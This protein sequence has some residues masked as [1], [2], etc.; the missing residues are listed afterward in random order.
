MKM[1]IKTP[2]FRHL[3]RPFIPAALAAAVLAACGGSNGDSAAPNTKPGYLGTISETT[4]D[5]AS[6][7]LLTAGLGATGLAAAVPPAFADPPQAHGG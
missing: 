5:G 6:S 7:D 1:N 3:S 4:Y 2:R